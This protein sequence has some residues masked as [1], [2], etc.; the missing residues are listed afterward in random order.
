MSKPIIKY[1]H[2]E[3]IFM[4]N[5]N[6]F[7]LTFFKKFRIKIMSV[8]FFPKLSQNYIEILEDDEY[9]DITI[10][11]GKDPDVK[12]FRAHMIILCYRSPFLRRTLASNKKS[13]DGILAH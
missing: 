10:E 8:Q 13:N 1:P 11:I 7:L 12:I 5:I 4:I 2:L 3:Q 6:I 9:H